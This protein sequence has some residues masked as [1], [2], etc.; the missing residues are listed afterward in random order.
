MRIHSNVPVALLALA[1]T[2]SLAFGQNATPPPA[3]SPSTP[4]TNM[5]HPMHP[6]KMDQR[7]R[8]DHRGPGPGD[9]GPMHSRMHRHHQFMLAQ[10]VS[11]P[12]FRDRVGITPEQAQK[13]RTETLDFRKTEIRNRADLQ[14]QYLDLKNL[15]S[16]D[17]P[18]RGAI[19]K[20]LDEI[21]STQ[22]AQRKAAINFHLDM[23]AALTPDQKQKLRQMREDFF[24]RRF[25]PRG[26]GAP[27]GPQGEMP[28][29][30]ANGE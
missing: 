14:I 16:A 19:N 17:S 1:L 11:R 9:W 8:W 7:A 12:E 27:D 18:D 28:S 21:G 4:A 2:S 29:P 5:H 23:R 3:P 20:Q 6:R 30:S 22:L 10:L 13:I 26:P 15:L 25:A 24:R